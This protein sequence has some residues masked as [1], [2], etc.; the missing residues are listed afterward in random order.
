MS[1][2]LTG[3]FGNVVA[4]DGD[5]ASKTAVVINQ[6]NIGKDSIVL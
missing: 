3:R 2:W 4:N 5:A 6:R 1:S